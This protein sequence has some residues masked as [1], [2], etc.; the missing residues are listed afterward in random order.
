MGKIFKVFF[1]QINQKRTVSNKMGKEQ[2]RLFT[3]M[4]M[5]INIGKRFS[6]INEKKQKLNKSLRFYFFVKQINTVDS[7]RIYKFV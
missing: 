7:C 1:P 2:N 6:F 3:D 5:E 4:E